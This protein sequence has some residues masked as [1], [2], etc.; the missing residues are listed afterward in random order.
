MAA[1]VLQ[2]VSSASRVYPAVVTVRIYVIYGSL[3]GLSPCS[4][5]LHL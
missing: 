4:S 1:I 3:V 2:L 5:F